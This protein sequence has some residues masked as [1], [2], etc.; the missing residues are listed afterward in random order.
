MLKYNNCWTIGRNIGLGL[1]IR[2]RD[3]C[4]SQNDK[5]SSERIKEQKKKYLLHA[6]S[7]A[8][9]PLEDV[10]SKYEQRSPQTSIRFYEYSVGRDA[11]QSVSLCRKECHNETSYK[12]PHPVSGVA[13]PVQRVK[14][15]K[16]SP[17]NKEGHMPG[18]VRVRVR[19]RVRV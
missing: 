19:V 17:N 5:E 6:R 2:K 4:V 8:W 3:S 12:S 15:L 14:L 18:V 1:A 10:L 11:S 7:G 16:N 13:D 9:T